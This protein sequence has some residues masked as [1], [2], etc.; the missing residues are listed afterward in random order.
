MKITPNQL[1]AYFESDH[2]NPAPSS[3]VA[4]AMRELRKSHPDLSFDQVRALAIE[5]IRRR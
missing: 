1:E 5:T 4:A 2:R 3:P